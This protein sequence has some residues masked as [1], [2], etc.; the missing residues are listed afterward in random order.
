M[1]GGGAKGAAGS[2]APFSSCLII[3]TKNDEGRWGAVRLPIFVRFFKNHRKFPPLRPPIFQARSDA[4][5]WEEIIDD[6][7]WECLLGVMC[8]FDLA[9]SWGSEVRF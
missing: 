5:G 8:W 2:A 4:L 1:K 9:V 6:A 7:S 3:M